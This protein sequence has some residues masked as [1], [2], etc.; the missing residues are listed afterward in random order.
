MSYT[1]ERFAAEITELVKDIE[2]VANRP[3]LTW[4]TNIPVPYRVPIW[5]ALNT[6]LDFNLITMTDN[7]LD[8][9]WELSKSMEEFDHKSLKTKAHY[10]KTSTPLYFQWRRTWS[11]I[12]K[13]DRKI[14][15]FD[16]YE[17]P[18]FFIP[19][20][21]AKRRKIK[22]IIGYRS[23]L[24]SRRFNGFLARKFRSWVFSLADHVVTVGKAS[25][26]AALDIGVPSEKIV[27]LFNPV[28]VQWFSNFANRNRVEVSR[29]HRFI[30]V[31]QL[32]ERKNVAALI[33]AFSNI[34]QPDDLLTIVG[35]GPLSLGL[36]AQVKF[37]GL[38][39][40]IRFTGHCDQEQVA[41]EYSRSDT[42]I[43]PSTEEV[44]GLVA[45][46]ALASGLH[47]VISSK[48]GVSEFVEQM[49]GV[50]IAEPTTNEIAK[51]LELSRAKWVG[52]VSNPEILSYTPER[53]VD[54]LLKNSLVKQN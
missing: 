17:S 8:R 12:K 35:D 29:G 54:A 13:Y 41:L 22:V 42:F 45:N 34:R 2:V 3:S 43:L 5:N 7:E 40:V 49:P 47:A 53:F 32:I 16:G 10:F 19:A 14:I 50:F 4:V 25:T 46:E 36:A 21:L 9:K 23:T 28:D 33:D 38:E 30:Y 18:A 39:K 37:L 27:T 26:E 24:N 15:Y 31:G 44:W 48:A 51:A 6:K 11:T 20:F 52:P 1:P